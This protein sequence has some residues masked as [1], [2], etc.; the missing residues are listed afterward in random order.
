MNEIIDKVKDFI[1]SNLT[2]VLVCAGVLLLLIIVLIIT[3]GKKK[4][5]KNIGTEEEAK[6]QAQEKNDSPV[7]TS[8]VS[9]FEEINRQYE[10]GNKQAQEQ[11]NSQT[12][13]DT[14]VTQNSTSQAQNQTQVQTETKNVIVNQNTHELVEDTSPLAPPTEDALKEYT[15]SE[16]KKDVQPT[17]TPQVQT[18]QVV[19][20]T[21]TLQPPTISENI[22]SPNVVEPTASGVTPSANGIDVP[23]GT[24][25]S[26]IE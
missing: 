22:A 4:K 20:N 11:F 5:A 3:S 26:N 16:T 21:Q 10:A 8:G 24:E 17:P 25:L 6:I 13:T 15:V 23:N 2:I 14:N 9:I 12:Q 18:Q 1:E 19:N 7:N